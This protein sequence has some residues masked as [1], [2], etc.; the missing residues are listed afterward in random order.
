MRQDTNAN[1]FV[2]TVDGDIPA[3]EIADAY[4]INS[5]GW[6]TDSPSCLENSKS[7]KK[8]FLI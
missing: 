6:V 5:D 7:F 8:D 1:P 2:I 3:L 4:L